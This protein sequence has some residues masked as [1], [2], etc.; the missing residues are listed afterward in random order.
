MIY[1]L[2]PCIPIKKQI[3]ILQSGLKSFVES[4]SSHITRGLG[5]P[6][7]GKPPEEKERKVPI[8]IDVTAVP[9]EPAAVKNGLNYMGFRPGIS[10]G[11]MFATYD[12]L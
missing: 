7:F 3:K 5:G 9:V 10:G 6:P 8:N 2:E 4:G 1:I 11:F 12:I